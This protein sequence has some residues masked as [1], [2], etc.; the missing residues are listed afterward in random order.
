MAT[1]KGEKKSSVPTNET[2]AQKFVRLGNK[3]VPKALKAIKQIAQ[4]GGNG[5]ESSP[6]QR[7]K[8]VTALESEVKAVKDIFAG[9]RPKAEA[10]TL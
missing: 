9:Q 1:K 7:A 4:L 6:E 8:I 2:K 3:R 10:F 5:Y